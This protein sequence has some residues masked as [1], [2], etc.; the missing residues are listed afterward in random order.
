MLTKQFTVA[1]TSLLQQSI[2]H[3]KARV[4]ILA[5]RSSGRQLD[6]EKRRKLQGG[7]SPSAGLLSALLGGES[8]EGDDLL[9]LGALTD[10][11]DDCGIDIDE[12]VGKAFAAMSMFGG[13]DEN[14][15][16][17]DY[18]G[19]IKVLKDDDENACGPEEE[20]NIS[21]AIESFNNCS[22]MGAIFDM[23]EKALLAGSLDDP[24]MNDCQDLMSL[25]TSSELPAIDLG[26]IGDLP[27]M[28]EE[29]SNAARTCINTL[30]G[31]NPVGNFVRLQYQNIDT[32]LQ[33]FHGL[34]QELPKCVLS[35]PGSDGDEGI[36][37]PLSLEKK[38][39]CVLSEEILYK[40]LLESMCIEL[41]AGLDACLPPLD[42]QQNTRQYEKVQE[43]ANEHSIFL[44]EIPGIGVDATYI[45]GKSIYPSFCTRV[46]PSLDFSSLDDRIAHYNGW[47]E[48]ETP[49]ISD[50]FSGHIAD[51]RVV[52][53]NSQQLGSNSP[54]IAFGSGHE[55][56][57][58]AQSASGISPTAIGVLV[59]GGLLLIAAIFSRKRAANVSYAQ[60]HDLRQ[61]EMA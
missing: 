8:P 57:E 26:D 17:L 11:A 9:W 55:S 19:M 59:L 18:L 40:P 22:G 13:V 2:L 53:P 29:Q 16:V 39:A 47:V 49:D 20:A 38:M 35:E 12:M 54:E 7:E 15:D 28:T 60:P 45:T 44:G 46:A 48:H 36:D 58:S 30:L 43:C 21:I 25:A 34:S 52:L 37:L 50:E 5:A 23:V 10:A 14:K 33:C 56:S 42:Q 41:H 61:I 24:L 4:P 27:G 31:D 1:V 6:A 3:D 51:Q 32:T